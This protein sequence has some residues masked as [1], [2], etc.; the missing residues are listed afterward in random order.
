[1]QQAFD[2][3][4]SFAGEVRDPG[5]A[6]PRAMLAAIGIIVGALVCVYVCMC[7]CAHV[8][9]VDSGRRRLND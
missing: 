7:F 4:A 2:S 5:R 9:L 3:A 6:Y 1:M 8:R